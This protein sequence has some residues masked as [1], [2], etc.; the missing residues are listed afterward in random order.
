MIK[1]Q[2]NQSITYMVLTASRFFQ[3]VTFKITVNILILIRSMRQQAKRSI[4]I[5][6]SKRKRKLVEILRDYITNCAL[7]YMQDSDNYVMRVNLGSSIYSY[8]MI[9][10]I[11]CKNMPGYRKETLKDF[12]P[13]NYS[14]PVKRDVKIKP[15]SILPNRFKFVGLPSTKTS[16]NLDNIYL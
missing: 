13:F 4:V 10:K 8:Q 11:P 15:I 1:L 9:T 3:A 6:R 16:N 5:Q 2:Y 14:I 7:L 12:T